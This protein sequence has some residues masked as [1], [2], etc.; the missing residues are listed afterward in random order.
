MVDELKD[1][2]TKPAADNQEAESGARPQGDGD[3]GEQPA[4]DEKT[5]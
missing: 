1:G 4:A 5:E 3:G 2:E